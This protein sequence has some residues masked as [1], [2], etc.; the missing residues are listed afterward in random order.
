MLVSGSL[1]SYFSIRLNIEVSWDVA[2][3]ALVV[4]AGYNLHLC[5]IVRKYKWTSLSL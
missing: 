5:M 3:I 2:R 1:L 4:M